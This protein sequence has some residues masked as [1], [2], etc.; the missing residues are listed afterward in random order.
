[1]VDANIYKSG[2]H[3]IFIALESKK[4][5]NNLLL[6]IASKLKVIIHIL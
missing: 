5:P 3:A 4:I 6:V 2:V 1:M